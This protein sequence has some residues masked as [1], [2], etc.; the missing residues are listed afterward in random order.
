MTDKDVINVARY[1]YHETVRVHRMDD[2][3][4]NNIQ[5]GLNIATALNYQPHRPAQFSNITAEG[6]DPLLPNLLPAVIN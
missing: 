2:D 3:I 1:Y 4:R 6:K 5:Q